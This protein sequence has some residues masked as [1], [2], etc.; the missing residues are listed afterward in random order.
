VE[1]DWVIRGPSGRAL[2]VVEAKAPNQVL[3]ETVQRQARS[4]AY[5]LNCTC[6]ILTNGVDLSIYRREIEADSLLCTLK[7]RDIDKQWTNI[8]NLLAYPILVDILD[9]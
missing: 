4:Y 6:Y 9:D 2:F 5:G 3:D 7:L 8:T 1:A